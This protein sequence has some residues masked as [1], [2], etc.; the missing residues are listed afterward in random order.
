VIF[1]SLLLIFAA[2][3]LSVLGVVEHSNALLIGSIAAS[4]LA[5]TALVVGARQAAPVPVSGVPLTGT[6]GWVPAGARLGTPANAPTGPANAA[7]SP[8]NA[9]TR[10]STGAEKTDA[11]DPREPR[12]SRLTTPYTEPTPP[13]P[14]G[15]VPPTSAPPGAVPV[16]D[17]DPPL[18]TSGQPVDG[19]LT[20]A[21]V[22]SQPGPVDTPDLDSTDL[23]GAG[24]AG[25]DSAR[26]GQQPAGATAEGGPLDPDGEP[27]VEPATAEQRARVAQLRSDVYVL[28]GYPRYHLGNCVQLVAREEEPEALPVSEAEELGFTPCSAC[29][30]VRTL[31]AA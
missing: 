28:D 20:G 19:Y 15:A 17:P 3:A 4:L 2:I 9:A 8:A 14:P 18:A 11:A 27:V 10:P 24:Q 26:T 13:A 22:P 5:A 7:T 31:L 6:D 29:A 25:T 12:S 16:H 21:S 1:G 23:A 30:P